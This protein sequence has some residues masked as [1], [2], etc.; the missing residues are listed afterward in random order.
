MKI[1]IYIYDNAEVLDFSGPYEV[2][3]T[4]NRV[5]KQDTLFDTFLIAEQEGLVTARS[6]YNVLPHYG[7]H[8]HPALDVLIIVGGVHINEMEKENVIKWIS[9]QNQVVP[10]VASVCTGAFLLAQAGVFTHH[11][12]TTHWEDIPALRQQFPKLNVHEKVRWIQDGNNISSGGISAGIDM[13][14]FIVSLLTSSNLAEAT[15]KQMEF[16]WEKN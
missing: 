1:G 16:R 5:T 15:A 11:N 8:N 3:T 6:G 13:S 7:I 12:V 2:F 10:L 14:L 9:E 4:A